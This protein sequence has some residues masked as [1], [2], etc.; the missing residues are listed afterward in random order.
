MAEHRPQGWRWN[1]AVRCLCLAV[2]LIQSFENHRC[3]CITSWCVLRCPPSLYALFYQKRPHSTMRVVSFRRPYVWQGTK[4]TSY[5]ESRSATC[6]RSYAAISVVT[7]MPHS[8]DHGTSACC[9]DPP[10]S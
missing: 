2:S 9:K 6:T 1:S 4:D 10:V 7:Q 3:R 5:E 8:A